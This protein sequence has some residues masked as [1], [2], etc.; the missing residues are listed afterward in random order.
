M[1]SSLSHLSALLDAK[2]V[3]KTYSQNNYARILHSLKIYEFDFFYETLDV[4]FV[5]FSLLHVGMLLQYSYVPISF[6]NSHK[7]HQD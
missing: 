7:K 5:V 4:W 6:D 3:I 2:F 1:C